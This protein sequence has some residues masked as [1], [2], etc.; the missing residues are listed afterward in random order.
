M[1]LRYKTKA[2][3]SSCLALQW[4]SHLDICLHADSLLFNNMHEAML[5]VQ[6][7]CIEGRLLINPG[8]ATGA[9]NSLHDKVVP[10]FVLM[11][12]TGKKVCIS[13][14][15]RAYPNKSGFS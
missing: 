5:S 4:G 3:Q 14:L 15:C 2:S 1:S 12:I 11:D 8:S 13:L 7:D 6:A 10:S 9:F